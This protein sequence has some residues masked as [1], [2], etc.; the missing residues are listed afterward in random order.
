MSIVLAIVLAA[1]SQYIYEHRDAPVDV[2]AAQAATAADWFIA[3]GAWT[4]DRASVSWCAVYREGDSFRAR[5]SGTKTAAADS[6][7]ADA[8]VVGVIN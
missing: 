6:L 7:P 1:A 5:C 8:K 3:R 4:G 2:T